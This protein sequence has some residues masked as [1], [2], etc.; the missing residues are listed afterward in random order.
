M[1]LCPSSGVFHCTHS[2]VLDSSSVHHQEFFTV[3]TAMFCTVPLSLIRSF[4]LYIQQWYMSYMFADSLQARCQ[5]TCMT[6]TIAVYTV[7]NSWWWTEELSETCR[8]SF[9]NKHFEKLMHLVG[10]II[11]N[12]T[13]C[14]VTWTSNCLVVLK[15]RNIP[16]KCIVLQIKFQHLKKLELRNISTLLIISTVNI[17]G[18]SKHLSDYSTVHISDPL[19]KE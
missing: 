3:H 11:R 4:S 19:H 9:Q 1:F 13:R 5:Q 7:K 2:N 12:L 17:I 8:V 15:F 14:T 16:K 10:F 6:Y 18:C